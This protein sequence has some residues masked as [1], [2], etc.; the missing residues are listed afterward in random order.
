[1]SGNT[2]QDLRAPQATQSI[3]IVQERK[4]ADQPTNIA[5]LILHDQPYRPESLEMKKI[6][7]PDST[8]TIENYCVYSARQKKLI[9]VAGLFAAFFS[10]VSCNIYFPA[11]VAIA[12]DLHVSPSQISLTVT[13]YQVSV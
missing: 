3:D 6:V 12:K 4:K 10:P 11:L 7:T 13:T 9:V 1:M 8:A 5:D 2:V